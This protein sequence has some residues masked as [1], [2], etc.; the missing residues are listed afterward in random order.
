MATGNVSVKIE[1][2]GKFDYE[3][4]AIVY[5]DAQKGNSAC[6]DSDQDYNGWFEVEEIEYESISYV[7]EDGDVVYI[8]FDY[9]NDQDACLIE[10]SAEAEAFQTYE[11]SL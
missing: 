4:E 7:D 9:I 1:V 6:V 2:V 10:E 8:N 11:Q 5:F 3:V